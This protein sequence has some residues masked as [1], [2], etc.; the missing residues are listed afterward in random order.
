MQKVKTETGNTNVQQFLPYPR[1]HFP[2]FQLPVVNLG[3]KIKI[4]EINN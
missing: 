2:G 3:Q 4:P 1:F